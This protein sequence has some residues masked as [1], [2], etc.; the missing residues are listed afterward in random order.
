MEEA[1][2]ERFARLS[3]AVSDVPKSASWPDSSGLT[4]RRFRD[5]RRPDGWCPA[6]VATQMSVVRLVCVA[7]CGPDR[8][9]DA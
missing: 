6:H 2:R 1:T 5:D 9:P 7:I 3:Y 4:V 8:C